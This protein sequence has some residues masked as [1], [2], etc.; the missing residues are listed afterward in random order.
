[1]NV[2]ISAK[3]AIR[4]VLHGPS[5]ISYQ[6]FLLT[7]LF[8]FLLPQDPASNIKKQ[9]GFV[10]VLDNKIPGLIQDSDAGFLGQNSIIIIYHTN[11]LTKIPTSA[12]P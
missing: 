11:I 8:P 9:S 12:I 10:L 3:M 1:M 7:E 4:F 2:K 5:V 6:Y